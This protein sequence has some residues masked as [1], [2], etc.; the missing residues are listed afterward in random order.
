MRLVVVFLFGGE[1]SKGSAGFDGGIP[2]LCHRDVLRQH[3]IDLRDGSAKNDAG[4][5]AAALHP[6]GGGDPPGGAVDAVRCDTEPF[7]QSLAVEPQENAALLEIG[8][9]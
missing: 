2:A 3:R 6:E 1:V 4:L 7:R 8:T 9:A 5:D